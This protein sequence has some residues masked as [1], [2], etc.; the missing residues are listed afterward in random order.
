VTWLPDLG[1]D[2]EVPGQGGQTT[3]LEVIAQHVERVLHGLAYGI[4]ASWPSG[5]CSTMSAR[6]SN[7]N[8]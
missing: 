4:A 6:A 2:L 7:R 3:G 5:V 8:G 1:D